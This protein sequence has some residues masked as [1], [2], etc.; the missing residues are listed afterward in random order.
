[1]AAKD[2]TAVA[3]KWSRNLAGATQAIT[4]GVNATTEAP[5]TKAARQADTWANNTVA[6]KAKFARNA[7]AVS[8][9]AWQ[10]ATIQKGVPRVAQGATAAEPKMQAVMVKLLPYIQSQ[11]A[12]LPPRGGLQA[13]IQR[14]VAMM[15]AMSKFSMGGQ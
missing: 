1:M 5:G 4:D 9:S 12:A 10:Q 3:Q 14:A 11:V 7:A 2:P 6:A 13:N 15:N 8:L